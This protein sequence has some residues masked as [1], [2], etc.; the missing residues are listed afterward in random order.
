MRLSKPFLAALGLAVVAGIACGALYGW[1]AGTKVG[2]IGV[3]VV[4]IGG[5]L[6]KP[7]EKNRDRASGSNIDFGN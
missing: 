2:V 1:A 5:V 3:V 4:S 7:P 6:I